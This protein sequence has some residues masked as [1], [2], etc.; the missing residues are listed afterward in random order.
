M[1]NGKE[2]QITVGEIKIRDYITYETQQI[3]IQWKIFF[4][5]KS[6]GKFG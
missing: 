1:E 6:A 4:F 5:D 3:F 2:G